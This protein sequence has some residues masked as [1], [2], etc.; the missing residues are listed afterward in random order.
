LTHLA[1][2]L[3]EYVYDAASRLTSITYKQNGITVLGDLTYEYDKNGN[4]T[5]IGGSFALFFVDP[6]VP[7]S[8]NGSNFFP[9]I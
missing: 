8:S 9:L 4:R 7:L 1:G 3:V 6:W 2:V 5:K